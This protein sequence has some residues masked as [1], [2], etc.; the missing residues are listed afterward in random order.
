DAEGAAV[1][2]AVLHLH[3]GAHPPL[4]AVDGTGRGVVRG[5]DIAD[6]HPAGAI[7]A[8]ILRRELFAIAEDAIDLAHGLEGLRLGLRGAAGDDDGYVGPVARKA[9]DRLAG[10]ADRLAGHRAGVDDHRVAQAGR[11]R[12]APHDFRLVG[13]EPAAEGDDLDRHAGLR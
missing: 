10:L 4:D 7:D 12:L 1:V 3:E 2:A 13:I 8:V 9:S 6:R 11:R 5:H